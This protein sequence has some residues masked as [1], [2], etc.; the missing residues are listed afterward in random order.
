MSAVQ[1]EALLILAHLRESKARIPFSRLGMLTIA[2][3]PDKK[4][5]VYVTSLW[6]RSNGSRV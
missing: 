2:C 1:A 5:S 6:L 3:E 4:R